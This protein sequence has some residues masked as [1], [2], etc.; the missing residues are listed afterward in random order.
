MSPCITSAR[1]RLAAWVLILA[2][3]FLAAP[4]FAAPTFPPL[5]GRVVDAA[6][7][8]PAEVQ[9]ALEANLERLEGQT[10]RQLVVVTIEDLQGYEIADYGYQLGR[11]WGIGDA[12]RD[13]G[14]LLIVAPNDR[15][16]R[17]EVGY[18]LEPVL[19][20]AI[21]STIIQVRLLPAARAGD[22]PGGVVAAADAIVQVLS[23]PQAQAAWAS[24]A[25]N[26]AEELKLDPFVFLLLILILIAVMNAFF[27]RR[28]AFRRA[29]GGGYPVVIHDW[30]GSGGGFSGG[31]F[32]G[33][34]FSGGGGS[35]GGGGASGSW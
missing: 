3:F 8:L 34:G 12:K 16:A 27:P 9:G 25:E 22:L 15:A 35:F 18:G 6:G 13:D 31:G 33:G 17:I 21:A 29:R 10:G 14:V 1:S 26:E 2:W 4:A 28:S 20:D 5:T 7:I 30:G 24:T 11:A 32:G 19:T 23:D